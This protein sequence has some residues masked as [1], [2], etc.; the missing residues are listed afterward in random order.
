MIYSSALITCCHSETSIERER[1]FF[2]F[3][4][5]GERRENQLSITTTSSNILKKDFYFFY[6]EKEGFNQVKNELL[7][8]VEEGGWWEVS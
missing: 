7:G 3:F 6:P 1:G 5:G 2:S 4:L 8:D